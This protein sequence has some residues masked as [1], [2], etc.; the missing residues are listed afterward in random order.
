MLSCYQLLILL[1][2]ITTLVLEEWIG[3]LFKI[4]RI[5]STAVFGFFILLSESACTFFLHHP[6]F[7]PVDPAAFVNYYFEFDR[8]IIQY[9]SAASEYSDDFF[10]KLKSNNRFVYSNKEFSDSFYTNSRGFRDNESSLHKPSMIFLGDSY[11][12]G[13]GVEEKDVYGSVVERITG[14]KGLNAG[15]SSYGTA[16][17]SA[18]LSTLDTTN[19]KFIV[20]QYCDND[21]SENEE[22]ISNNLVLP[23]RPKNDYD[24]MSSLHR[25]TTSYFPGKHFLT[26]L[27]LSNINFL[28]R[29]KKDTTPL[30][31]DAHRKLSAMHDAEMFVQI[32]STAKINW[33]T[34]K[35]IVIEL[36]HKRYHSFF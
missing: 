21:N 9:N 26:L 12:L 27:K 35:V 1:F 29:I 10:Y 11:T 33:Q 22:F 20:W 23:I 17:E 13:W 24:Q 32:L 4:N 25:W 28:K 36:N 2:A 8:K 7:I 31:S 14:L 3:K 6:E 30:L 19:L 18:V 16:R 5:R 34:T 15:I